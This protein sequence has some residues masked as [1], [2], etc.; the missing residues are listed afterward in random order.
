MTSTGQPAIHNL[1]VDVI[2]YP[3]ERAGCLLFD[4]PAN[5]LIAEEFVRGADDLIRR[6]IE[7]DAHNKE[8]PRLFVS[9]RPMSAYRTLERVRDEDGGVVYR[10]EE[11]GQDAWF[12]PAFFRYFPKAPRYLYVRAF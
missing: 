10:C 2:L 3:Y 5:G 9:R 11:L 8:S 4:D 7:L 6:M 1:T 12:C